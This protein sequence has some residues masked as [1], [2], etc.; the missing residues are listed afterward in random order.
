MLISL[1]W[2]R[3]FVDLPR[4][5]SPPELGERFTLTCAEIEGV[6]RIRVDARGLIA[7]RVVSNRELPGSRGLRHVVLD[8]GGGRTVE[9]VTAAPLLHVG[10]CV[11]YAPPGA[12]LAAFG[13]IREAKVEGHAS[14]G[15]I[16]PGEAIGIEMAVQTA[17]VLP[18]YAEPG[19]E[20]AA[21]AFDDWVIEVDNKSITHR[22]D[23]WGHYG[24][25]R[26][27]AAMYRSE[28]KPY[29]VVP[30]EELTDVDLPEI[31]ITIDD[32]GRC[33]R[34]SGLRFG[35][36]GSQA[37]P[38]WMQLR[39]G[40]VGLRP[41]DCLV[42]LTNYIMMELGQPMHAFDGDKVERIEVGLAEPRST[43][44]TLDGIER[45]LPDA[46]LMIL[47]NRRPI[48]LAGIMGGLDTEIRAQTQSL[49][50]ES[51]NFEPATIR[52]CANALGLR[53]DACVRFEKSLDPANTVLAIQRFMHLARPEFPQMKPA[54]RLS[55]AYPEP[56]EPVTV[57][58]D[59]HFAARFMGHPIEAKDIVEILT[60]LG[61]TVEDD[62]DK[63]L[64]GVPSWRATKDISIEA[65]VIEEVARYV[66][67]NSIEPVLPDVEVRCF[68]PNA[69]HE[70]EQASLRLLCLGL[71]F[72]EIHGYIWYDS[73]WT[74]RLG[75][76]PGPC[77]E[78]K[79]PASAA[80]HLLRQTLVP[81]LLAA[82]DLNRH[83]AADLRLVELGGVFFPEGSQVQEAHE[84]RHLGLVCAR[85]QK[86][87]EETLLAELKGV[88]ETWS[89]QTLGRPARFEPHPADNA[90]PWE[91]PQMTAHVVVG[92][93]PAGRL[94]AL[95]LGL[96]RAMDEHLA[97]WSV[98]WAELELNGLCGPAPVEKLRP[99]PAHPEVDLDFSFLVPVSVRYT[100][101]ANQLAGFEHALLKRVSYVGC[102]EGKS[103]PA[104]R[105]SLTVRCRIGDPTRTLVDDDI[106]SFRTAFE[107]F[108]GACG[109][110]L[111]R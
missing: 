48:A 99:V 13:V 39:L 74:R 83:Y 31:P 60:P 56:A 64:V 11:V 75:F 62:A 55:D 17:I 66:G 37:A 67:Y 82:V 49:L 105:R 42:D 84:R 72:S 21:E 5:V 33:P 76:D 23:L 87:A 40:H 96:R 41:I 19:E 44:V 94:S 34:Y 100:A 77:C 61:F 2:I 28:L 63:L 51:A 109:W 20:L 107:G 69:Q 12:S 3:D 80:M 92:D 25:A 43:F 57:E 4:D 85:R 35:S 68:E 15:M 101:V 71:S 36:V 102:Y 46:A 7:A 6:E 91:H 22:P 58:V 52:R 50:L 70:V 73:N 98:A 86:G 65:D 95:P 24:I 108:L 32:P 54:S 59:P 18:P 53:T 81:G 104:G 78:L 29:P 93:V 47:S 16:L 30:L 79:N 8:V 90:R 1:N 45:A 88:V 103:V 14:V 89:G 97:A 27:L 9:T 106:A 110:S 26:E 10:T 111:R 38:L